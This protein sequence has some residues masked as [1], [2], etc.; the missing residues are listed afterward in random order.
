MFVN[1]TTGKADVTLA[2]PGAVT[3]FLKKNP[4]ALKKL[5]IPQPL[6]VFPNG[7]ALKRGEDEF[8][9]MIDSA[10]WNL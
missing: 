6:R 2:E 9:F 5:E 3:L 1:V 7:Y 8:K 10:L 4:G